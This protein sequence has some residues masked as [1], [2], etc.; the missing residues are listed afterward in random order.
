MS[1]ETPEEPSPIPTP[2]DWSAELFRR[3]M[4]QSDPGGTRD[5]PVWDAVARDLLDRLAPRDPAEE[6]LAAQMLATHAR[7]TFL[8]QHANRQKNPQWFTLYSTH[9]QQAADLFRRQMLALA[10]YRRPRRR[11][12]TFNAI[13]H[14]NIAQ[15]MSPTEHTRVSSPPPKS[16]PALPPHPR[17]K[18]RPATERPGEPTVAE[19][20]RPQ[21]ADRQGDVLPE[22]PEARPDQPPRPRATPSLPGPPATDA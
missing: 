16:P 1:D 22:R 19:K 3:V 12:G 5:R 7:A 21:D 17:R 15:V 4:T 9:A 10:E 18:A 20:H 6:M 2:A 14:A 11:R 13:K 8:T